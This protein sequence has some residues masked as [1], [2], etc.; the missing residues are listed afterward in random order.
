MIQSPSPA[1]DEPKAEVASPPVSLDCSSS[2]KKPASMYSEPCAMFTTRMSP[3]M[4]VKP[5]ATT[6]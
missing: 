5:L 6:K 1:W 4:S 2:A 3:K